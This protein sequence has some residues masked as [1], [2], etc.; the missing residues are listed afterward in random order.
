[1][2]ISPVQPVWVPPNV[3][4]L[5]DDCEQEWLMRGGGAGLCAFSVHGDC[6]EGFARGVGA[7]YGVGLLFFLFP[8]D[9]TP[10]LFVNGC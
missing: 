4:F 6:V 5:V 7:C 9:D 8:N 2:D 10:T 1:M 3:D